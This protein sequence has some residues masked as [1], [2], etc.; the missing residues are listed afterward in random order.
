MCV[1]V[2]RIEFDNL[3]A[4]FPGRAICL[5]KKSYFMYTFEYKYMTQIVTFILD[6]DLKFGLRY[7]LDS[8]CDIK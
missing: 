3:K 5:Q 8:F 2:L 4:Y 6:L 7:Q 1:N